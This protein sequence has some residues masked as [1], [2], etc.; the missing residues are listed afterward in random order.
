V[1]DA[2]QIILIENGSIVEQGGHD[3]LMQKSRGKYRAL[4]ELQAEGYR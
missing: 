2:D 1:R 3:Q 4:F